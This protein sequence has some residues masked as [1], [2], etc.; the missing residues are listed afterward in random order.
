MMKLAI[1]N[2]A[3]NTYEEAAALAAAREH[4]LTGIEVAPTKLWPEW[5]G[6]SPAAAEEYARKLA[7]EGFE[8]PALQS[9]LY[10]TDGLELFASPEARRA[11]LSHL[12]FVADLA[13]SFG[14]R[15]LV[16]GSPKNRIRGAMAIADATQVAAEFFAQAG[17]IC[18]E[19]GVVL[20]IEMS[21]ADYKCDFLNQ[22]EDTVAFVRQVAHPGIQFHCDAAAMR[23]IFEDPE[24]VINDAGNLLAHFHASEPFLADFSSP[25]GNHA[26]A[27]AALHDGG[28][29]GWV[30]IEMVRSEPAVEAVAAAAKFVSHTYGRPTT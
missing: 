19:R 27:A 28:Y 14:A 2:I 8:I 22:S 9:L 25:E 29:D 13:V 17:E 1:S 23:L 7:N 12:E 3:W 18:H 6:A 24:S 15:V 21:P 30:S 10:A 11:T 16:F 4:G 20:G 5:R 26:V